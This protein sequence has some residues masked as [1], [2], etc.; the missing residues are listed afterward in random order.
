MKPRFCRLYYWYL[1]FFFGLIRCVFFKTRHLQ[2]HRENTE[3]VYQIIC[4]MTNESPFPPFIRKIGI[5]SPAGLPSQEKLQE[6]CRLLKSWNIESVLGKSV[7][8]QGEEEYFAADR[9][10]RA[11]DLNQMIDDHSIDLVLCSRG[12]YGSASI[13]PLICWDKLRERNLPIAGYS[14]ITAIHM[15]MLRMRA[16]IPVTSPMAAALPEWSMDEFTLASA[17]GVF[18]RIFQEKK[19][20]SE[21]S[22]VS[23]QTFQ[24]Q[25]ISRHII[26]VEAPVIPGNLSLLVSLCGTPWL[27]DLHGAI[28]V[29]E[30]V[31]ELPR[32]LDRHF[33]QLRLCGI[34]DQIQALVFADFTNCG[35]E[36]ELN[37]IFQRFSRI[38]PNLPMWKGLPFGHK[39][40]TCCFLDGAWGRISSTG[41]FTF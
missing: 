34:L 30:D 23:G 19:S 11:E 39:L 13:L 7:V 6:A 5:V 33:T 32:I 1:F 22:S 35:S 3:T 25:A 16:G 15:A 2:K 21:T 36:K 29:V 28:L 10:A 4:S 8:L 31:G 38:H 37:R 9:E 14:D 27:P 40:P 18:K 24:L 17:R 41:I 20:G 26:P 12:G